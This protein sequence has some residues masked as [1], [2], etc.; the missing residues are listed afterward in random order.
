[1]TAGPAKTRKGLPSFS[2]SR[3]AVPVSIASIV[4]ALVGF[5]V[6]GFIEMI[7]LVEYFFMDRGPDMLQ[8]LGAYAVVLVPVCGGLLIGLIA[9][10]TTPGSSTQGVP[11]VLKAIAFKG[12][13][14]PVISVISRAVTSILAIGT[15]FSVG[16]EGPAVH[17]GA[18]IGGNI[19]RLLRFSDMRMKNLAACGAA[20]GISAVFNAPITG[21][22][23]ASEVILEDFRARALSTVV[24]ASVA[25]S[26]VSRIFLGSSPAF[27]VPIYRLWSAWEMPIYIGLGVLSAFTAVTFIYL[28][29]RMDHGFE[30]SRFP[31]WLRPAVGGLIVGVM[32][33]YLPHVFGMGFGVIE[34][35][36]HGGLPL[37]ILVM[38]IF[39]KMLATSV[40]LGAGSSGGTFAP[41]LFV[42]GALGGAVG[43]L[44][45]A[46]M[47]FDV[48]PPGA[49]T[50]VG[51]ASVF[52]GAFHAPVTAILLVFEMTG[53]YQIILPLMA[54]AVISAALAQIL[55]RESIDTVK[56][57]RE[58]IDIQAMEGTSFLRAVQVRDAMST[59]FETVARNLSAREL[60]DKMSK[61]KERSFYAVDSRGRLAGIISRKNLQAVL[62]EQE[63]V[64]LIITDDIAVP[65]H[66]ICFPDE[67]LSEAA[68]LMTAHHLGQIPVVDPSDPAK[69]IGI[70]RSEDVFHAYTHLAERRDE[71][72]SRMEQEGAQSEDT[73]QVRFL[74]SLRSPIAGKALK[75]LKI[76]D[77]VVLTSL[78]RRNT[79]MIPEGPTV[80]KVR[81]RIWAVVLPKAES[82]FLGWM[83]ENKLRRIS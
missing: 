76:P 77:G 50:L 52:A 83:K 54:A 62:M 63:D 18:G 48:A 42:G 1:M 46:R 5:T 21:V 72:L 24:V 33:L 20:A 25:S 81:D 12:G 37:T 73:L 17:M 14:L 68:A 9:K 4:G 57:H 44:V 82:T 64:A 36:L 65:I 40:S 15:G 79:T 22:M 27:T 34:Q 55:R 35:M 56:F 28:L 66:E 67:P 11:E 78:K 30:N 43:K 80:L 74:I 31:V 2:S 53:D 69:I 10:Y 47:P 8:G 29:D 38:L 58:G 75:E 23:F 32:G 70:L 59:E 49:Y 61:Q 3:L 16:R 71:L 26:I 6:V 45:F 13:R 51:M 19:G 60:I 7:R 39:F 41:T